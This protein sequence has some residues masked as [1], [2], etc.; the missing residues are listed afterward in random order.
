[1]NHLQERFPRLLI[2]DNAKTFTCKAVESFLLRNDIDIKFILSVSPWRGG[3][4]ERL[5]RSVKMPLNKVLGKAKL[6]Y[7]E[8]TALI[9]VEGV[10]NCRPLTPVY[11]DDILE[12]LTPS[13]LFAGR[14]IGVK[15]GKILVHKE[16][17]SKILTRRA[18]YLQIIIQ[19][20]W[21]QFQHFYLSE[22]REHHMYQSKRKTS[23]K[24]ILKIVD[25]VMIKDDKIKSRNPWRIGL[26]ESLAIGKD[27]NIR[28]ALFTTRSNEGTRPNISRPVRILVTLALV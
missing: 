3:F 6:T 7:E 4:Y 12:P 5:V 8:E 18:N 24:N 15:L 17:N 1:M 23:N 25:I 27:G 10:I 11:D 26:V 16:S 14:N 19:N 28:G 22:L 9:E 20:Y 21:K 2:C 13:H